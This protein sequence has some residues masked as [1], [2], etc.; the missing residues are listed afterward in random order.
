MQSEHPVS[1]VIWVSIE[2][3]EPN[4]YNPNS[5]AGHEMKLLHTS[6]K[7]DGYTQPIVT[8]WD[9]KKKKYVIVDGFHRLLLSKNKLMNEWRQQLDITEQEG[10]IV[11]TAC[12]IWCSICLIMVGEM[13]KYVIT[14]EWMQM[15]YCV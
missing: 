13:H 7:H 3:V 1:N 15:N 6:I 11:S 4:D 8:I 10:H 12:L 14:L 5:V 2:D 9:D